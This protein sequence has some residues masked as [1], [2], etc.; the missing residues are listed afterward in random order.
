MITINLHIEIGWYT[1]RYRVLLARWP[2]WPINIDIMMRLTLIF[3]LGLRVHIDGL[4]LE[5]GWVRMRLGANGARV[6]AIGA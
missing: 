3:E 4:E 2:A 5:F 6:E 1:A